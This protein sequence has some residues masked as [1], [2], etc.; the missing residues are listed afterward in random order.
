MLLHL[1][2][3][4]EDGS[5]RTVVSD[6]TWKAA[7]GP[8]VLDSIRAG[9]VHDARRENPGWDKAGF[10]DSAW[11]PAT[12]V[13]PPAGKLAAQKMPPLRVT[14]T[15]RPKSMRETRPGVF[16]FDL[17]QNISGWARLRV[18]GPAGARVTLRYSERVRED[19]SF[20]R[21]EIS[22]FVFAGP[23][24]EDVYILAGG[25]EETWEP[26]F[27]YH[28]FQYVEVTGFPGNPTLDSIEGR[29]VHTDFEKAGEFRCADELLNR[30]QELTD[31]SFRGNYHG[32]PTDCPQREKNGWTG[33]A[34]LAAEQG[35][36]NWRSAAAYTK[37]IDDIRDEQ[38]ESGEI[39][40]IIPTSGW[41]YAWGNGPA[42]DSAYVLI[43]WYV[44]LYRG[45]LRILEENY[46][47]MKR[48]VDYV[49]SRSP[50]HIA[51][52]GL[53]DWAPADTETPRDVTST[54]YFHVD[55]LIVAR[56]AKL[57]CRNEDAAKY[58]RLAGAIR[59]AF[60]EK[61]SDRS[62]GI[63]NN[64][65]TALSCALFQD[66]A[67]AEERSLIVERLVEAVHAR[68]DH[69]DTGILGAKYLFN[70]L[71]E[72]GRH[73]LAYRIATQTTPP[74]YGDWIE[75]GATTL[76]E[77]WGGHSSLNHIMFG[78][79]SAW[80]FKY[81][82]GIRVDPEQ[83]GFEHVIIHPQPPAGLGWAEASH[84][85]MRGPIHS[86]WERKN[87]SIVLRVS[88]PPNTSGTVTLPAP[89]LNGVTESGWPLTKA[90]GVR[91]LDPAAG[92]VH[93]GS[94]RYEFVIPEKE[95][96]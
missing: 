38:Q 2:I 70:T 81:L 11:A 28:G 9:E 3:E 26:R 68:D 42:W 22:K 83:P 89:A 39:A 8:V 50:D 84:H 51:D 14:E 13:A 30:I 78:D 20:D 37:W 10:E 53:G 21:E 44:Y 17:G 32:Y 31:W 47:S 25:S 49:A 41:G 75:R 76:W 56:A 48:Y 46:E 36:Y 74:S 29:V 96:P 33:D 67:A 24:Q 59:T 93:I 57:L 58:E 66:L 73:E 4:G 52:F 35:L 19:G 45:D 79:I 1:R 90:E 63:A 87:G 65:Q 6:G 77:H 86:R 64:S 80:M 72:N 92:T 34:H 15:I 62:G 91:V 54:G 69:L 95:Q 55:S 88:L 85:S 5:L 16:L 82:A 61:F 7:T 40:A 94:G 71:S 23:F 18:N 60:H 12:V 27:S 43:P